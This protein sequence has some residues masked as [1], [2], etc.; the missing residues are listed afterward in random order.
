MKILLPATDPS[1]PGRF[2][3]VDVNR[4]KT[5]ITFIPAK[6]PHQTFQRLPLLGCELVGK[7]WSTT[8]NSKDVLAA[9][10]F[11]AVVAPSQTAHAPA[12]GRPGK[13]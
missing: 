4:D 13:K 7:G 3:S 9:S 2:G 1:Q 8:G 11:N 10:S 6:P 5:L 12:L